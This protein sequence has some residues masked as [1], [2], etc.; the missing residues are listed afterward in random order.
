MEEMEFDYEEVVK[1]TENF[2]PRRI[3]G[4]GSHGMVYK[5]VLFNDRLQ[6]AVKKPSEGLESLFLL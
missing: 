3:I 5:G 4:K 1:A 2:N 6:V